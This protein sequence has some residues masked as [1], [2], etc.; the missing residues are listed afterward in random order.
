MKDL[1]LLLQKE[2]FC[3]HYDIGK[4]SII[5]FDN[6]SICVKRG[7]AGATEY[8]SKSSLFE[9]EGED[10]ILEKI[11]HHLNNR[12]LTGKDLAFLIKLKP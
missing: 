6:N 1:D 7:T 2:Y 3:A 11:A 12:T 8:V 5:S 9:S 4:T 10:Y